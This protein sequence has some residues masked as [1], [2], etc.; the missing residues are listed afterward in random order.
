MKFWSALAVLAAVPS[1]AV[2]VLSQLAVRAV[3]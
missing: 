1:I 2:L 3:A